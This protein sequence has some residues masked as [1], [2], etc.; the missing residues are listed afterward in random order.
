[1]PFPKLLFGSPFVSGPPCDAVLIWDKSELT[2]MGDLSF[3]WKISHEEIYV[4]GEGFRSNRRRGSVLRYP[5]RPAWTNHPDAVS[6]LHPN[7]KPLSLMRSLLECCPWEAIAD[8][9]CGSGSTLQAA[10]QLGKSAIGIEI[11]EKYC[12]IA[13]DRLSQEVI[14][15]PDVRGDGFELSATI[16]TTEAA[17]AEESETGPWIRTPIGG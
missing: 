7:E 11:E 3:P 10:K 9:T 4:I 5:L 1:L 12:E 6:G 2:G 13:A 17:Q 8:P 14:P 15:F 16:K